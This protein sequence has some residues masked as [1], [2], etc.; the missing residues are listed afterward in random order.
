MLRSFGFISPKLFGFP[1]FG[2]LTV[3]DEGYSFNAFVSTQKI[4]RFIAINI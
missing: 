4:N 1:V 3:P 2:L